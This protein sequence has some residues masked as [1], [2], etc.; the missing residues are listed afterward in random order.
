MRYYQVLSMKFNILALLL[1]F[2]Y[3]IFLAGFGEVSKSL[4]ENIERDLSIFLYGNKKIRKFE[5]GI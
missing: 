3:I 2:I 1:C 5:R 4:R